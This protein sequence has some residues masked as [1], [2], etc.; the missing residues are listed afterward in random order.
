M[1]ISVFYAEIQSSLGQCK[2]L[3]VYVPE[4]MNEDPVLVR[5]TIT[6]GYAPAL[7]KG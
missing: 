3:N 2:Y 6:S 1:T 4:K 7:T 5:S